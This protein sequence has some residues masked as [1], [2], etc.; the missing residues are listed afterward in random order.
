LRESHFKKYKKLTNFLANVE[1]RCIGPGPGPHSIGS[2]VSDADLR[3]QNDQKRLYFFVFSFLGSD[4]I[5]AFSL[6][7][8]R[9]LH[10]PGSGA[11]DPDSWIPSPG[12]GFNEYGSESNNLNSNKVS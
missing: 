11:L 3:K 10:H 6:K 5:P 8:C 12:S 7:S 2:A 4:E 1:K 9:L